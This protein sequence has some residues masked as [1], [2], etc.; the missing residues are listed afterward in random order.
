M[1][2]RIINLAN[3]MSELA[4]RSVAD[5][6]SV[7]GMTKV[8]SLNAM[9]EASRAGE[10]GKGF[11][12]VAREVREVSDNIDQISSG[13][14]TKLVARATELGRVGKGLVASVRGTRLTDLALNMIDIIDRNLYERSCDVRWWATDSALVNAAAEPTP[15]RSEFASRRLGVILDSYTV[16]LDIWVCDMQGNV[17]ANGRPGKFASKGCNVASE[18]WFCEAASSRDGTEFSVSNIRA[19]SAM[20]NRLVATYGA[21]IRAA[22]D[23]HGAPIGVIGVF[24]DWQTQSQAVVD[25]VRLSEDERSRTRC[26]LLDSKHQVIA[27]SDRQGVLKEVFAL[28]TTGKPTGNYVDSVGS[29]VG[30]ALTPGYESYKGLGWYGVIR[31][32]RAA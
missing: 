5:I 30:Y 32:T 17:I 25:A 9:I 4:C 2:E 21:A 31:Q 20:D 28:N 8:L 14:G 10:F 11:A 1:P 7:T 12:I 29:L 3:E 24:F 19:C 6:Q 27:A 26:L 22:G 18:R 15:E 13:L 16:Y 23:V